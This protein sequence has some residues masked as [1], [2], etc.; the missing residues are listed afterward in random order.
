MVQGGSFMTLAAYLIL[1]NDGRGVRL[2]SEASFGGGRCGSGDGARVGFATTGEI[3]SV[4]TLAKRSI[5]FR[6]VEAVVYPGVDL[7]L[8]ARR[9]SH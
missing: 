2:V 7:P 9:R 4:S 8:P 3:R 5:Y 1:G 6:P